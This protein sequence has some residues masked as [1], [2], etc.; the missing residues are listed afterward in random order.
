M[1]L[2]G[3]LDTSCAF[4]G[5]S[6]PSR[7]LHEE[8]SIGQWSFLFWQLYKWPILLLFPSTVETL[9]L[10]PWFESPSRHAPEH[11]GSESTRHIITTRQFTKFSPQKQCIPTGEY[12]S[13]CSYYSKQLSKA[14]ETAGLCGIECVNQN[15]WAICLLLECGFCL[16]KT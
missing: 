12:D 15:K 13:T 3:S 14:A 5:Q 7:C 1:S 16:F 10:V 6:S 4:I 11:H 8:I 9:G 2:S